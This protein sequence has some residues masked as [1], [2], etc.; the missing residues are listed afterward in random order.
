M[1]GGKSDWEQLHDELKSIFK[2]TDENTKLSKIILIVSFL[3]L[4]ASVVF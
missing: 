3:S 4:L 2:T 1:V